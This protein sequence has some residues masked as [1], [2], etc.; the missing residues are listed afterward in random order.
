MNFKFALP[1]LALAAAAFTAPANAV[2]PVY[3]SW[4]TANTD[5]YTFQVAD[6]GA[7]GLYYLDGLT[8]RYRGVLSFSVNG[9]GYTNILDSGPAAYGDFFNLGS[10]TAGDVLTFKLTLIRPLA[11]AGNEIYS[12]A[13]LNAPDGLEQV[14]SSTYSGGDGIPVGSYTY[15]AFED[16]LGYDDQLRGSDFDYND[17][18]FAFTNLSGVV[19]EPA[20][21]ALLITG[22][23]FV[24]FA[25][26]RRKGAIASVAA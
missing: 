7:V 10:F 14:F 13:S 2:I 18:R 3:S 4:G 16:V 1:A 5:S 21:W 25:L 11:V 20:T 24:G 26:R 9:G 6:T 23:G 19:P 17:Q 22:F 15:V 8:V 12:D